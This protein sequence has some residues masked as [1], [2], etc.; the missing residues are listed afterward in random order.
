VT[1]S[2]TGITRRRGR[3]SRQE[4]EQRIEHLLDMAA[5]V[6]IEQ[7]YSAATMEGIAQAAGFWKQAIY[8]RYGDKRTLFAAVVKRLAERHPLAF[9]M[10]DELP[11]VEGLRLRVAAMLTALLQPE[12]QAI[13]KLFLRDSH[14]FPD[15]VLIISEAATRNLLQPLQRYLNLQRRRGRLRKVNTLRVA[16][17]C[18]Y[19]MY[20][21]M[22]RL[23]LVEGMHFSDADI[24]RA[25][26]EIVDILVN[27]LTTDI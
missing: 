15:L 25:A 17:N 26:R 2:S 4:A 6:F 16:T 22:A 8:Q 13:Y 14:R 27:S 3:P 18:A 21:H 10:E 5:T 12:G 11:L 23:L 7:G 24:K 9:P 19:L 20:G 1:S